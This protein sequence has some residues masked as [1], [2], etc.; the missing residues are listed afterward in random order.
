MSDLLSKLMT[1]LKA[2][3]LGAESV[4]EQIR[5]ERLKKNILVARE[6]DELIDYLMTDRRDSDG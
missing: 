3:E 4:R 1:N 5:A 6:N 2:L